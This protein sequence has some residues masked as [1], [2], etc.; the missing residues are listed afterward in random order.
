[1]DQ[2]LDAGLK[3]HERAVVR[4]VGDAALELGADREFGLDALPRIVEQLLHAER[5]AVGFVVDLDDLDLH[6]LA[7][8]EHLGRVIDAAPR[9]VGDVQQTIDAAQIDERAVIGDV[10]H[11]AVDDLAFFEVLHQ[12]LALLG[13]G[14]FQHGAARHDD[15]AAAAVHFENLEGLRDV[16]QRRHVADRPDVDLRARQERDRA[17]EIDR[18]AALDLIEDDAGDLLVAVERLFELAPAFLAARLVAREN[19]LAE[20][21]LDALEI[22]LDLVADLDLAAAAGAGELADRDATLGLRA[23]IDQRHVLLDTDDLALDDGAFLQIALAECLIEHRGEIFARRRG[24]SSGSHSN[25][26]VFAHDLSENRYPSPIRSRTCFSGS[27][28]VP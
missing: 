24:S 3:L 14:L 21:V 16:H 4:D 8:I 13:A 1:M 6:L 18:K 22:D 12:L 27:C 20:R 28:D 7:D 2:A 17:V 10:L 19:R 9:D 23:D 25:S 11:H 5:D 26:N 15:V